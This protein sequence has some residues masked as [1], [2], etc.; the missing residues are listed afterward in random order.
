MFRKIIFSAY[1]SDVLVRF[2]KYS[3]K[4]IPKA[5]REKV[6]VGWLDSYLVHSLLSSYMTGKGIEPLELMQFGTVTMTAKRDKEVALDSRLEEKKEYYCWKVYCKQGGVSL[7]LLLI[8]GEITKEMMDYKTQQ[9]L[10]E[11]AN[12]TPTVTDD[13]AIC[14]LS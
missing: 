11:L 4:R 7:N 6:D 12:A 10:K 1:L 3:P 9:A 2:N 5:V 14:N 13:T 8:L